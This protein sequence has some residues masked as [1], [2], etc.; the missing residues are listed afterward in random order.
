LFTQAVPV[1]APYRPHFPWEAAVVTLDSVTDYVWLFVIAGCFGAVGGF[2]YELLQVRSGDQTGTVEL[3]GRRG[4]GFYDFGF[5][6][7]LAL[8]AIAAMAISYFF[9]PEVLVKTG[10]PPNEVI[11]TKWQIVKVVPLSIIVGSAGGAFLTA[12]QARVLAQLNAQKATTT[13]A[14]SKTAIAQIAQAARAAS[15]T[16]AVTPAEEAVVATERAVT[17][18]DAQAALAA[19]AIDSAMGR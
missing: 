2:A 5:F 11:T 16:A 7:S 1:L 19:E 9:T 15:Q 17:A 18:I 14:V 13:A 10:E 4:S 8:G 12:M 3:A 6:A